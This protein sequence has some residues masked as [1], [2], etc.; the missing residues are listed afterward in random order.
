MPI[1]YRF[2]DGILRFDDNSTEFEGVS[3]ELWRWVTTKNISGT[4][5]KRA[6]FLARA[7]VNASGGFRLA[8]QESVG[9]LSQVIRGRVGVQNRLRFRIFS[10]THEFTTPFSGASPGAGG[11]SGAWSTDS[12]PFTVKLEVDYASPPAA[13]S[14]VEGAVH[15]PAG[16]TLPGT[17]VDLR[18]YTL[19]SAVLV[20][21]TDPADI[22]PTDGAGQFSLNHGLS[23]DQFDLALEVRNGATLMATSHLIEDFGVYARLNVE[24]DWAADGLTPVTEFARLHGALHTGLS[25]E[26]ATMTGDTVVHAARWKGL[27]VEKVAR[28]AGALHL[29]Q[30]IDDLNGGP[31]ADL[32]LEVIYGLLAMGQPP[33]LQTLAVLTEAEIVE[34]M[35]A[36]VDRHIVRGELAG[37]GADINAA[38]DSIAEAELTAPSAVDSA[39]GQ[40][41]SL[42]EILLVGSPSITATEAAKL[43]KLVRQEQGLTPGSNDIWTEWELEPSVTG[44]MVNEARLRALLSKILLRHVGVVNAVLGRTSPAIAH[45]ADLLKLSESDLEADIQSVITSGSTVFPSG[46]KGADYSSRVANFVITARANIAERFPAAWFATQF[47]WD[48]TSWSFDG[49]DWSAELAHARQFFDPT[50]TN[51]NLPTDG[52][53]DFFSIAT[54][55]IHEYFSSSA[56]FS[57]FSPSLTSGEK[58]DLQAFLE[59]VQR[60]YRICPGPDRYAQVRELLQRGY[61]AAWSVQRKARASFVRLHQVALGGV[62]IARQI[63]ARAQAQVACAMASF[64]AL[65][66]GME[67]PPIATLPSIKKAVA[68]AAASGANTDNWPS[69]DRMFSSQ[70]YCEPEFYESVLSPAA[71]LVDLLYFLKG[72][73]Q[74][75]SSDSAFD[76]LDLRRPDIPKTELTQSGTEV[77]LPAIDLVIELLESEIGGLDAPTTTSGTSA[78]RRAV[79]ETRDDHDPSAVYSGTLDLAVYPFNLPYDRAAEETGLFLEHLGLSLADLSFIY[80]TTVGDGLAQRYTVDRAALALNI[81]TTLWNAIAD[82]GGSSSSGNTPEERWGF[83]ES[84]SGWA[85]QLVAADTFARMAGIAADAIYDLE[86]THFAGLSFL[87]DGCDLSNGTISFTGASSSIEE[88]FTRTQSLL[89]LSQVLG[90]RVLDVDRVL[91]MLDSTTGAASNRF[92]VEATA[93]DGHDELDLRIDLAVLKDLSRRT[94][95]SPVELAVFW[96]DIDTR[97][98]RVDQLPADASQFSQRFLPPSL[99]RASSAAEALLEVLASGSSTVQLGNFDDGDSAGSS[100]INTAVAASLGLNQDDFLYLVESLFGLPPTTANEISIS[101]LS[102]LTRWV[103]LAEVSGLEVRRLL[104][105]SKMLFDTTDVDDIWE[106]TA[107]Y[108]VVEFLDQLERWNSTGPSLDELLWMLEPDATAASDAAARLGF[109]EEGVEAELVELWTVLRA[110][111]DSTTPSESQRREVLVSHVASVIEADAD[112]AESLLSGTGEGDLLTGFTSA[113]FLADSASQDPSSIDWSTVEFGESSA[114]LAAIEAWTRVRKAGLLVQAWGLTSLDIT[115]LLGSIAPT[116]GLLDLRDLPK[117]SESSA[118]ARFLRTQSLVGIRQRFVDPAASLTT[119]LDSSADS[120]PVANCTSVLAAALGW[121]SVLFQQLETGD[122]GDWSASSGAASFWNWAVTSVD[123]ARTLGLTPDQLSSWASATVDSDLANAIRD[124]ARSRHTPGAWWNI[125]T[126]LQDRLRERQ[127]DA[128]LAYYIAND[129][130]LQSDADVHARLLLDPMLAPDQ[131]TSRVK[132]TLS[133]VQLFVHRTMLGLEGADL[134]EELEEQWVWMKNYRVWEAAR[135]V[136]LWPENWIEPDLRTDQTELFDHFESDLEAI[137]LS[138]DQIRDAYA[139]YLDGLVELGSLRVLAFVEEQTS[140]DDGEVDD[141]HV[142]ARTRSSPP[143]YFWRTWADR[144]AWTPWKELD[145]DIKSDHLIPVI[146]NGRLLLIWPVWG[147]YSEQYDVEVTTQTVTP[148]VLPAVGTAPPPPPGVA[149]FTETT[150]ETRQRTFSSVRFAV[151]EHRTTGW[152]TASVSTDPT[153]LRFF[154]PGYFS[155]PSAQAIEKFAL[156][157]APSQVFFRAATP[158]TEADLDGS[159]VLSAWALSEEGASG[160]SGATEDAI[161]AATFVLDECSGVLVPLPPEA[162]WGEP[163][164]SYNAANQP[165]KTDTPSGFPGAA[166]VD[167]QVMV[168]GKTLSVPWFEASQPYGGVTLLDGSP[169]PLEMVLPHTSWRF[170]AHNA[171]FAVSDGRRTY[172]VHRPPP[173]PRDDPADEEVWPGAAFD[174]PSNSGSFEVISKAPTVA[175]T[176]GGFRSISKT[177]PVATPLA[178]GSSSSPRMSNPGVGVRVVASMNA[179]ASGGSVKTKASSSRGMSVHA[180]PSIGATDL[181]HRAKV[182]LAVASNDANAGAQSVTAGDQHSSVTPLRFEGLHHTHVCL[183]A[184]QVRRH[185]VMGLLV[186]DPEGANGSLRRQRTANAMAFASDYKPGKLVESPYPKENIKFDLD[187]PVGIYNWELFF[188]GPMT[189]ADRMRRAQRFDLAIDWFHT[190]FDP[191]SIESVV[192]SDSDERAWHRAQSPWRTQPLYDA[193]P[194]MLARFRKLVAAT[195]DA[196][197]DDFARLSAQLRVWRNHPFEPHKIAEVRPLAYQ[198][199]VVTRYIDTLIEWGD[200]LFRQDSIESITEATQLYL[201]AQQVLGDRPMTTPTPPDVVEP[202]PTQTFESLENGS[203]LP[204]SFDTYENMVGEDVSRNGT[205][206]SGRS[207]RGLESLVWFKVPPNPRLT[208]QWDLVEDRLVKIRNGY[209]IAGVKRALPLF[210]PPIDPGALVAA[211][212]SGASVRQAVS[213]SAPSTSPPTHRYSYL[214]Q[215]AQQLVGTAKSLGGA[216]LQAMEKRDAEALASLRATHEQSILDLTTESRE[217]EIAEAEKNVAAMEKQRALV[218]GR[219]S[220][221]EGLLKNDALISKERKQLKKAKKASNKEQKAADRAKWTAWSGPISAGISW[222]KK[223]GG[224]F[225][226]G[227]DAAATA[228]AIQNIKVNRLRQEAAQLHSHSSRLGIRA[229]HERRK[230]DWEF[231]VTNAELEYAQLE[232]Q[233]AAANQRLANAQ[234]NLSTHGQQ[235]ANSQEVARYLSNKFTN[236]RLY[237][238][239]VGQLASL[240]SQAYLLAFEMAKR[241]EASFQFETRSDDSFVRYGHWSGLRSGLLAGERLQRD[242]DQMDRTFLDEDVREYELTRHFSLSM[243][244]PVALESLRLNGECYFE[245]SETL[246]D[247]DFPSHYLRRISTVSISIPAV[248]GKYQGV[249]GRL[250][251]DGSSV[252]P[253]AGT[254]TG[255]EDI[256][257]EAFSPEAIAF[258]IGENDAGVFAVDRNSPKYLPFERRGAHSKWKLELTP[259]HKQFDWDSISD[260]VLTMQFTAREGFTADRTITFAGLPYYPSAS[261]SPVTGGAIVGVSLSRSFPDELHAFQS[262][263]VGVLSIPLT[264]DHLPAEIRAE[265]GSATGGTP[266]ISAAIVLTPTGPTVGTSPTMAIG[267]TTGGAVS[268]STASLGIPNT[269]EFESVFSTAVE[270]GTIE[271]NPGTGHSGFDQADDIVVMLL[272]SLT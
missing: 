83:V 237:S 257:S 183:M 19:G 93:T 227:I 113:A 68:G 186:P 189:I 211:V 11:I 254:G 4:V 43:V 175:H 215:K 265:A 27:D 18:K 115:A 222:S 181:A 12:E 125:V 217:G 56:D 252:R 247:F 157:I 238:W 269:S 182:Y 216:L 135:K 187:S 148:V 26:L 174:V 270:I 228:A 15:D 128:L 5:S 185:G 212:A 72:I 158:T 184:A 271:F 240:Y 255:A 73:D 134:N 156:D 177:N 165:L 172:F 245:L 206:S 7:V 14:I 161:L 241:A 36:A 137:E 213:S 92:F 196:A 140:D 242:L 61:V 193:A 229:G 272:V 251:L 17:S 105:A 248:T 154:S 52:D 65:D 110:A 231:Q 199:W 150:T 62:A 16:F 23:P 37:K 246:F 90:W 138:S 123:V 220:Y 250:T 107:K 214:A 258:C 1:D 244:D 130:T 2:I 55:D 42:Q 209:N 48:S 119:I 249:V 133:S 149:T 82:D 45:A 194:A 87:P 70:A 51:A 202:V 91:T 74:D 159:L 223:C 176:I 111:E 221:Y 192:T 260:V 266:K 44:T 77:T 94:G 256:L 127:R 64:S 259:P 88:T 63:Y 162:V 268:S 104:P 147:Q 98:G 164:L 225:S 96:G 108:R 53:T 9:D 50:T 13:P 166:Q 198:K 267:G 143:R 136:F 47:H 234:S 218:E 79:P 145:L 195:P 38:L 233:L 6:Q 46:L 86:A 207:L 253:V 85:G 109:T 224:G 117:K 95:R 126:P 180:S 204:Q 208:R 232:E 190:V 129:S 58:Q 101:T 122:P 168:V 20:S 141:V 67:G 121:E 8:V 99:S 34:L 170:S 146:H 71:Y 263:S 80:R 142:F 112:T 22:N 69:W 54:T 97:D 118:M 21:L 60:L 81:G 66:M 124:A 201:I 226:L 205:A 10:G 219:K 153:P 28:Y 230:A 262:G 3:V 203:W 131:L 169:R 106:P 33:S 57:M 188:H 25:G 39:T 41:T 100:A 191:T 171:V 49:K 243:V 197:D 132:Q 76:V 210:Q 29:E 178:G 152:T 235:V 59:A 32:D 163:G 84:T 261:G 264:E 103:V 144:A 114:T 24:V 102:A 179:A 89:R 173:A 239:M 40:S 31:V 30:A 160:A 139:G 120:D 35:N 236:E 167:H 116:W 151:S 200:H 155:S 78:E 75:S